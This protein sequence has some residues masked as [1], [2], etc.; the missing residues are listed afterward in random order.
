VPYSR[1]MSQSGHCRCISSTKSNGDSSFR[2]L[3][4]ELVEG[5]LFEGLHAT[6]ILR[7]QT[8]MFARELLDDVDRRLLDPCRSRAE[9]EVM[10]PAQAWLVDVTQLR[11][12]SLRLNRS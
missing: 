2:I 8:Q 3:G 11:D 7:R 1:C 4:V 6:L 9:E 12:G 5:A 10:G